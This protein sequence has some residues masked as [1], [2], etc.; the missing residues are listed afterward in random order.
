MKRDDG[1]V[2]YAEPW[3]RPP[4]LEEFVMT[5]TDAAV[6]TA[7]AY[8]P[9]WTEHDFGR[10]MRFIAPDI[11]CDGPTGRLPGAEAFRGFMEPSSQILPR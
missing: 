3:V 4:R 1:T 2:P 7:L 6:Q 5:E 8:S 11:S 9:A 10:A